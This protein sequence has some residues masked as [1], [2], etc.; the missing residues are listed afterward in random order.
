MIIHGVF[1]AVKCNRCG[2]ICESGDYQYWND[3]SAAEESAAESEW[4][5]DNGKHYCPNCHEI[6]E[7]DNVLIYLPI[8]ESVKKA[9]IFLQSI[10]RYAVLKDRKDSFRIEIS[11]IQYLSD[12]DLAWIR[13]KIDFEIEKV[14][15]PRQEKI[16]IIIKK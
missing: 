6:D 7:N 2:N 8:P 3:E 5:I 10:T 9:Q 4:H 1:F 13:S 14:V 12:A 15:T 11:N 16:I